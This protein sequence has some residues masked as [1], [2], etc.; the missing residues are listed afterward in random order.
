MVFDRE[1][2][3]KA[4]TRSTPN[5]PEL[6]EK[7]SEAEELRHKLALSQEEHRHKETMRVTELGLVGR[8]V[9]GESNAALTAAFLVVVVG[10]GSAT[11]CLI[12]AY[13]LPT[14][15]DFWA[16]QSERSVAL[17]LAA[18]SFIFGKSAGRSPK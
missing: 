17:A 14:A 9:G 8:I 3:K 15:A 7:F 5:D 18:L 4:I 13:H 1:K 12:A 6:D 10:L 11:G 2:A 16:K